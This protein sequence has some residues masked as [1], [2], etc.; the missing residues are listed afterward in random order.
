MRQDLGYEN[1]NNFDEHQREARQM[2]IDSTRKNLEDNLEK[3]KLDKH[4]V[5]IVSARIIF[6]LVSNNLKTLK[7]TT[8]TVDEV[9]LMEAL[10]KMAHARR[11]GTQEASAVSNSEATTVKLSTQ[12]RLYQSFKVFETQ[13]S[14]PRRLNSL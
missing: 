10:L 8:P 6:S 12:R 1:D 4:D 11:Y 3:A 13:I 7:K 2:L 9:R 14:T 5:F